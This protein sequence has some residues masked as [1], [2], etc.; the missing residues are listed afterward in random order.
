MIAEE[1]ATVDLL[2]GGRLDIG[3]GR[4][5]QRYEFE[6]LGSGLDESR[7]RW[8][9]AVDIILLALD[10]QALQL[11]GQVLQDPRDDRLPAAGAEAASADLGH[12]AEPG[13]DRGD[14]ERSFNCCRAA[15]ACRSS[16]SREFR[17]VFDD[18]VAR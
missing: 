3:L 11:R 7:S 5:Y 6:R 14:G 13:L 2:T 15:S 10:G 4:G 16:G 8:E 18:T 17:R 12:R 9:E 1:I